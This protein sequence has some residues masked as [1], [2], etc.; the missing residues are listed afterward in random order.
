MYINESLNQYNEHRSIASN[1]ARCASDMP[2]CIRMLSILEKELYG[3]SGQFG[4]LMWISYELNEDYEVAP[5]Q[6]V[7]EICNV[8]KKAKQK[9][10]NHIACALYE[11][12]GI[13]L[14][15]EIIHAA[16]YS[17]IEGKV[18]NRRDL[19]SAGVFMEGYVLLEYDLKVEVVT[20]INN[21][22]EVD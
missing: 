3:Q 1:K 11:S 8:F 6:M 19:A 15:S 2:E 17:S 16:D 20:F 22:G 21:G 7:K 14:S 18:Q 12:R 10:G 4:E 9:Y 13:V 5:A